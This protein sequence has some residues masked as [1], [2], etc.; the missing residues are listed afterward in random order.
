MFADTG[1]YAV[2]L[3]MNLLTEIAVTGIPQADGSQ[4]GSRIRRKIFITGPPRKRRARS[5]PPPSLS[6][7]MASRRRGEAACRITEK[8]RVDCCALSYCDVGPII[9][10]VLV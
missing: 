4:K 2:N 9:D 3:L 6:D 1:K 5:K 8:H 7:A 10:D